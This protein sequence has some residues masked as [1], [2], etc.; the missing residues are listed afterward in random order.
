MTGHDTALRRVT[1]EGLLLAGGGRATLLQIAHPLV[2][3]GVYEHSDFAARPL[4]RLRS[5]LLYSY[6]V[7]FGS[8]AEAEKMSRFVR[9]MHSR[10]RGPGYAADD[11]ALLVW[12]NA[13]LYDTAMLLYQRTFGPLSEADA[14]EC[15]RRYSV[16]ATSIGCPP[17]AWPPD[18]AAFAR[19]YDD[20]LA[21]L[22]VGAEAREIAGALLSTSTLPIALRPI[23]PLVRFVTVGLLP[24]PV[25]AG[26]GFRWTARQQ[27]R[28]DRAL[29]VTAAVY[30]RLPARLR[31]LPKDWSLAELRRPRS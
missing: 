19:Y 9:A 10:V 2:A 25:R 8:A 13:T 31:H 27:R 24:E 16:V 12:V 4:T 6:A 3:R 21:S 20:M 5:T 29:S 11:P 30:P 22:R 1:A 28:L 18:R 23:Q 26:Y 7:L 15:H 17:D 14:D